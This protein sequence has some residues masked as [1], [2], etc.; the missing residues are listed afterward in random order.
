MRILIL[1]ALMTTS[2]VNAEIPSSFR[3][4]KKEA[5]K[6]YH[7]HKATFYCGCDIEWKGKKG[8]GKPSLESCGFKVRKQIKR[9]SRTEW[10]HVMPAWLFGHQ[11]QCWQTGKRKN[12]SKNSPKFK[13]MESDLHNLVPAIGEVNGDRSNYSFTDWN[14]KPHQYGQCAMVVDFKARQVQPPK[15]SRGAIART[16]LYMADQY[17]IKLSKSQKQLMTAWDKTYPVS[18]WECKRDDRIANKQGW[19]NKFVVRHCK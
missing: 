10:E 4:A 8:A 1:I 13:T 14:G 9:A 18:S 16:Y 17:K 15:R 3:A 6:I 11:L 7:D 5:V 12:C 19:N 2:L